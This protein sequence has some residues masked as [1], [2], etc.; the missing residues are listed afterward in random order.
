MER[1]MDIVVGA[2]VAGSQLFIFVKLLLPPE[3]GG[4]KS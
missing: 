4:F 3:W 1:Y 2:L